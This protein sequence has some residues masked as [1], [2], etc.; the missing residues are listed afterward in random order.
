M[1]QPITYSVERDG[2]RGLAADVFKPAES[3]KR[4]AVILLHGGGWK[5]GHRS[6]TYGYAE[7]LAGHGFVAIAAEYRLVDEAPWPAQI[8]DV[9]AII[10]W[11]Q[12]HAEELGIDP[13]K[14]AVEGFSAGGHLS[15]LAA[16]KADFG[17]K[18]PEVA[19][20]VA[21]FAPMA[22]TADV[23]P[24]RPPPIAALLGDGDDE[25]A[26]L[27]SPMNYMVPGFPPVFL[28]HGMADKMVAHQ[29]QLAALEVLTAVGTPVDLH[30]Y[31]SQNHEFSALPSLLAPIHAEVA[32]FLDRTVVDPAFYREEDLR[33]NMFSQP[34]G[35][36]GGPPPG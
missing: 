4:T 22:F 9:Q 28:L 8:L 2:I 20:A 18:V 11:A 21:F 26:R 14:I 3:T 5:F 19:A 31:H 35:P 29:S 23:M 17:G 13:A 10:L 24:V 34:G 32:H 12:D 6:M 1:V 7:A 33:L 15:L 30:F 16:G 36:F 27:A 25:A